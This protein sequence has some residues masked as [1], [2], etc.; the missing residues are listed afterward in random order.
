MI[1]SLLLLACQ[2]PTAQALFD[3]HLASLRTAQAP[4]GSY[5]DSVSST[6][7]VLIAMTLCPRS[8]RAEDG[9]F[10]RNAAAFLARNSEEAKGNPRMA[11]LLALALRET[12]VE[13]W[14]KLSRDLAGTPPLSHGDLARAAGLNPSDSSAV[15]ILS[16]LS[17]EDSIQKRAREAARAAVAW[18]TQLS[19]PSKIGDLTEV[20]TAAEDFLLAAQSKSGLWEVP[21]FG[22]E[23][24]ITALAAKALLG[25]SR[26][27]VRAQAIPALDFLV[28]LQN[29]DGSIH[30]G[31]LPVYVTSAAV[32]A[33]ATGGREQD[34]QA[35]ANAASFLSGTQLDEGEG[36]SEADKFYGGIGY[37][38][39]L[40]PDLSNLQY[41][42]QALDESGAKKSDPAFSRALVFLQRCQNRSESNPETFQDRDNPAP[43][44]A[45]NDGGGVYYP[46]NSPAGWKNRVDGTRVPRSY[47]SMSYALLKCYVLAG[48]SKED[49][50][51]EAGVDW[52][53]SHWTLEVNP[54]FDTLRDPRAGFQG[55][56]YYYLTLAEALSTA[57]LTT[58]NTP[59]GVEHDWRAELGAQLVSMQQEDGSWV[60]NDAPRWWEGNPILCTAYAVSA[61]R[62]VESS[63]P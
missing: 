2:G 20:L 45:G 44:Q 59:N 29:S 28:G 43:V 24:G 26:A 47:G 56:Y 49:P 30:G 13:S 6:A 14:T 1:A 38:N 27:E 35:L 33:L 18:R 32:G 10:I 4:D 17:R 37:G 40:R 31:R 42:L 34:A 61:L 21:P 62:I 3:E 19:P 63:T 25:S 50:R 16:R 36:Y 46:G 48:L 54:G 5:G 58:L 12:G 53:S 22:P 55:L 52:V 41:A 51:V 11:P 7:H 8:Y 39:D 9:P 60:N 23:P 57:K 15:T